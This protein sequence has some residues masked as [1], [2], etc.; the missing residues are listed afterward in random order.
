VRFKPATLLWG[1]IP[2]VGT[3]N[4]GLR[5]LSGPCPFQLASA[6]QEMTLCLVFDIAPIRPLP[7]HTSNKAVNRALHGRKLANESLRALKKSNCSM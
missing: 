6:H 5:G 3:E 2:A 4:E 7:T 1:E